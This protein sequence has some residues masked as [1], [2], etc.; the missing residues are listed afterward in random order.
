AVEDFL[1]PDRIIIGA[2]D[3]RAAEVVRQLY[4]PFLRTGNPVLIMDIKTAELT[5]YAANS[6]LAIRISFMNEV[7]TLC[8]KLGTDIDMVRRGL[9]SDSRIGSS[10]LFPGLGYGGSCFPKDIRA[11]LHTATDNSCPLK[12]LEAVHAVNSEQPARFLRRISQH[13]DNKLAG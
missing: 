6:A 2:D 5:K 4:A 3:P 10:F 13:F 7:A 9:G 11:L 1:K 8:E 12:I